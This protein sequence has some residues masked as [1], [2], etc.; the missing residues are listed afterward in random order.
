MIPRHKFHQQVIPNVDDAV[1][2]IAKYISDTSAD[3]KVRDEA[4]KCFQVGWQ[5]LMSK[6]HDV[7]TSIVV[8][9]LVFTSRFY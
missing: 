5:L 9:V 7:L 3:I 1:P 4:L 8:V 2:L 6:F